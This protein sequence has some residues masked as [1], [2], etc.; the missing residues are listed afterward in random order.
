MKTKLTTIESLS[1]SDKYSVLRDYIKNTTITE[2]AKKYNVPHRTIETFISKFYK[3]FT[4]S[5][6]LHSLLSTYSALP[7]YKNNFRKPSYISDEL[8]KK[9]EEE[10]ADL[11]YAH[12]YHLTK[13]NTQSLKE[14]S[15]FNLHR[16]HCS[17]DVNTNADKLKGQYIRSIPRVKAELQRLR[18]EN[19]KSSPVNSDYIRSS[20]LEQLEQLNSY[21]YLGTK[22][23]QL[24]LRTLELLGKS[25]GAYSDKVIVE[26]VDPNEALDRLIHMTKESTYTIEDS[27]GS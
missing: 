21:E 14:A 6:E 27:N 23:R 3:E 2:I 24:L 1:T 13:D 5:K 25:V 12:S 8:I 22:E 15:L 20:L 7:R 11:I 18:E 19:L 16:I 4:T 10:D 17:S 9:I 26:T